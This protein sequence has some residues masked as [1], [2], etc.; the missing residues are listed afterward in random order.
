MLPVTKHDGLHFHT[1]PCRNVK[2]LLQ[3]TA[4]HMLGVRI[5]VSLSDINGC[6]QSLYTTVYENL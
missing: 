6:L 5:D 3:Q 4:F 1:L 2:I